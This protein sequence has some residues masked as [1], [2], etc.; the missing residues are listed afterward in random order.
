MFLF[1][2]TIGVIFKIRKKS[3]YS[4]DMKSDAKYKSLQ[5]LKVRHL[6]NLETYSYANFLWKPLYLDLAK[7]VLNS[8]KIVEVDTTAFYCKLERILLREIQACNV[9][10]ILGWRGPCKAFCW[11]VRVRNS[12]T[13]LCIFCAK[14]SSNV[15]QKNE[16]P[17]P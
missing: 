2:F 16:S 11:E 12:T 15:T 13:I 9:S 8:C 3:H 6:S 14:S 1:R 5:H 4:F 10:S 7:I 17:L